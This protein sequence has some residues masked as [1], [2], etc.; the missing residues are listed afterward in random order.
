MKIERLT[1]GELLSAVAAL[2]LLGLMSA[3]WFEHPFAAGIDPDAIGFET[4][5]DAWGAFGLIDL[6]L[7]VTVAAAVSATV[8]T[9]AGSTIRLPMNASAAVTLLGLVS[10]ALLL[11]RII[12]PIEIA[13]V[14]YR[15]NIPL[16]LGFGST[17][18]IAA[19]GAMTMLSE[20]TT[21]GREL[22][23]AAGREGRV[24]SRSP[25]AQTEDPATAEV[26]REE[27]RA[28]RLERR[29]SRRY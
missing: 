1:P 28:R 7:L 23:R 8:V 2:A 29:S 11:Y 15:R 27:R 4:A 24:P 6:V 26:R 21:L 9:A 25:I 10:A 17:I 20:G 19:G 22:G 12:D 14:S 3:V 16:F 13:G 18:L 5:P